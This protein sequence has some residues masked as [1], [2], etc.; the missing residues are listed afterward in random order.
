MKI[1]ITESQKRMLIESVES[2]SFVVRRTPS[3]GLSLFSKNNIKKGDEVGSL[4]SNTP[5]ENGREIQEGLFETN[6]IGRYINHSSKPN[7]EPRKEGGEV[8]LYAT[9]D[10]NEGD[11]VTLHYGDV[12]KMLDVYP[13]T[14]LLDEFVD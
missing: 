8:I 12:E 11:E 1:I 14:F 13:G 6:V 2:D 9:K 10:I 5:S 7:T 4:L 3:K